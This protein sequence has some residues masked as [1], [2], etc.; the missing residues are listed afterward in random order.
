VAPSAN[1]GRP[2]ASKVCSMSK[3]REASTRVTRGLD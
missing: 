1:S 3:S 2:S